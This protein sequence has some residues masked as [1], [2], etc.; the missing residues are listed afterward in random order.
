VEWARGDVGRTALMREMME[1]AAVG[2]PHTAF[3][4]RMGTPD[5]ALDGMLKRFH[6]QNDHKGRGIILNALMS[7]LRGIEFAGQVLQ[8]LPK[9]AAYKVMARDMGWPVAQAA[10]MIRNHIGIPNYY[11]KGRHVAQAGSLVPFLNIFLRGYDSL[12]RTARGAERG[13]SAGAW[14]LAW[15]LTGGG[16]ITVLQTLAR[17]GM[18]GDDLRALYE[19]IPEW[20]MTNYMN[21]PLGS[22]STGAM[23]GKTVYA[24]LPMDEG[25]R[26]INATVHKALTGAI[27]AARGDKVQPGVGDVVSGVS[28]TVPGVNPLLSVGDAW[29]TYAQGQNPRDNF[30]NREILTEDEWRAGGWPAV[31][32]MLGWTLEQ[33]GITNFFSYDRNA[34]SL[35]EVA[36][37]S[38]PVLN[39]VIKITDRG[40]AQSED[41]QQRAEDAVMARVRAVLPADVQALRTEYYY[42]QRR[43]DRM[44]DDQ[45]N[46]YGELSLWMKVYR[47]SL[48]DVETYLEMGDPA[49]AADALRDLRAE[50]KEYRAR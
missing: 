10:N 23:G 1:A 5:D 33:T 39:R 8:M 20:D 12:S 49:L 38:T 41:A 45:M 42:L 37:G 15:L 36:V 27:R 21:L 26:V 3:G 32:R 7:P 35:T 11:K 31:S 29:R 14:W 30:R 6:V 4:G 16:L 43:G 28:A 47:R 22:V 46:R 44:S 19:R 17:E 48:A 18:M 2:G 34:D 24:R 50:S 25:L 13:Q 40:L 9:A